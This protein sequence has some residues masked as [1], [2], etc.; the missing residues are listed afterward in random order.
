MNNFVLILG[1]AGLCPSDALAKTAR[2]KE[3]LNSAEI[4]HFQSSQGKIQQY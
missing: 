4:I 2:T 1:A 3:L